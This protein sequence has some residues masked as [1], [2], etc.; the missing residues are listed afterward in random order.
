M[1][2]VG[3]IPFVRDRGGG[4][5]EIVGEQNKELM[6]ANDEEAVAR[7]VDLLSSSELQNR[8]RSALEKQAQLFSTEQFSQDIR[9]A[10]ETYL[11]QRP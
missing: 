4:Q 3:T 7:I 11:K 1:V 6:F 8:M 10:I 9:Q 5:V 2:K